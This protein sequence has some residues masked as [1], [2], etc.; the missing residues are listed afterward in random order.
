MKANEIDRHKHYTS[1]SNELYKSIKNYNSIFTKQINFNDLI[2][3]Q[4]L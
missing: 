2:N 1:G 3:Y 4:N